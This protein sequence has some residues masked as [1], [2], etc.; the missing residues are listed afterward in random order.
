MSNCNKINCIPVDLS[1]AFS[2][3]LIRDRNA[4]Y[5]IQQREPI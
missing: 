4:T 2:R 5:C 1:Y 3:Q